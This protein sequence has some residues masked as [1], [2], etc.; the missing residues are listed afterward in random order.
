MDVRNH[1]IDKKLK[2]SI[3]I[4]TST[5]DQTSGQNV[6]ST[7]SSKLYKS[8]VDKEAGYLKS[9]FQENFTPNAK[10]DYDT[11]SKLNSD[12]VMS[13]YDAKDFSRE[14]S[15]RTKKLQSNIGGSDKVGGRLDLEFDKSSK[16][17]GGKGM[18]TYK[19]GKV[20]SQ[21]DTA[22]T[23]KTPI[24]GKASTSRKFNLDSKSLKNETRNRYFK[25]S[26]EIKDGNVFA[27]EG[28]GSSYGIEKG[29]DNLLGTMDSKGVFSGTEGLSFDMAADSSKGLTDSF[30]TADFIKD[31][32]VTEEIGAKIMEKGSEEAAKK[33][34]GKL[35]GTAG[36]TLGTVG[37]VAGTAAAVVGIGKG[38]YDVFTADTDKGKA[39]GAASAIGG[40]LLM[41]PDP[42]GLTKIAGLALVVGGA[43]FGGSGGGGGSSE[44]GMSEVAK[45][46]M[47]TNAFEENVT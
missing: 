30:A 11:M 14:Y 36:K 21:G 12:E 39:A 9:K 29:G 47:R 28:F 23:F 45:T 43:L 19:G 22:A 38:V 8:G 4:E 5:Y 7:E 42:T 10:I 15:S 17:S 32:G 25:G 46:K 16:L 35:A 2:K 24:S 1:G 27:K 33:G 26:T 20:V 3:D 18:K 6:V 41:A 31:S 13:N 40:A 34:V 44:P 37:K